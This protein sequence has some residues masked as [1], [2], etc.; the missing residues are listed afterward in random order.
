MAFHGVNLGGWLVLEHWITPDVF[1]GTSAMDEY[2][3]CREL[4]AEK[5]R[6][7]FERHRDGFIT[8]DH[9]HEL[10]NMGLTILR[11]PVGYWLFDTPEPFVPGA[12]KYVDQL[13]IW[14]NESSMKVILDVH[15]APGSQNGWDHS[16]QAGN[17]HWSHQDNIEATLQL[18]ERL[19]DRYGNES[20]LYGIEVLNEPHW[21]ISLNTLIDYYRHCYQ[22][23][24]Q[25]CPTQVKVICSD[26]FRPDQVSKQLAAMQLDRIVLDIHLYQLFTPEDQA[27]DL[28]GHLK[29][30]DME[31]SELLARLSKRLPVMVG[32]WSAAMDEQRQP[33][34]Q[35]D[36]IDYFKTQQKTFEDSVIGWTYW[37]AR[38]QHAGP[39]S[40]LDHPEFL[41]K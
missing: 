41:Q 19:T 1:A 26:S 6:E 14:A 15:A 17:T 28:K 31:W 16:G 35:N 25:A 23:I 34:T 29:K 37:T 7:R 33:Y 27:L 22:I 32:E 9:I 38:T 39:W 12:D 2:S 4:G 40:L 13:F 36:Y 18:I 3:L 21:D 24:D 11:L 20:A 10:A 30:A 8:R 5:A